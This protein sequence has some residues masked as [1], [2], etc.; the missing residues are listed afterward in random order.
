MVGV[1]GRTPLSSSPPLSSTPGHSAR[2]TRGVAPW[3]EGFVCYSAGEGG[4]AH[5]LQQPGRIDPVGSGLAI[6]DCG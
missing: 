3:L 4:G 2:N 6:R 5:L 1:A